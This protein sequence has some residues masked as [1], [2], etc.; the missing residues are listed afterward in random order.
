M[1]PIYR[2][3]LLVCLLTAG[4]LP[5]QY[6]PFADDPNTSVSG[7]YPLYYDGVLN[8]YAVLG[9]TVP[10]SAQGKS[11]GKSK[12][13]GYSQ[14]L[15]LELIDPE[16]NVL[17][18]T[19]LRGKSTALVEAVAYNGQ[20][21]AVEFVDAVDERRYVL[22]FDGEG[23]QIDRHAIPWTVYTAGDAAANLK[24]FNVTS[25]VPV[26]TGFLASSHGGEKMSLRQM[27]YSIKHLSNDPEERAW[28]MRSSSKEKD[29]RMIALGAHAD[30]IGVFMIN[31]KEGILSDKGR[32]QVKGVNLKTGK[33]A[34]S[35]ELDREDIA[36]NISGG[37]YLNGKIYLAGWD[38]GKKGKIFTDPPVGINLMVFDP[39]T[40]LESRERILIEDAISGSLGEMSGNKVKGLGRLFVHEFGVTDAGEVV[41]S[42]EFYREFNGELAARDG[43]TILL[44][45]KLNVKDVQLIN[46]GK[47][48][49]AGLGILRDGISL[50]KSSKI[51]IIGKIKGAFDFMYLNERGQNVYST[52]VS[53][54]SEIRKNKEVTVYFHVIKDGKIIAEE[55]TFAS[56]SVPWILPAQPGYVLIGDE[57][58]LRLERLSTGK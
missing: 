9:R 8:G 27:N 49:N 55:L 44:D 39:A 51:A 53:G 54:R 33:E 5:A 23:T 28:Y 25:L 24:H 16:L 12:G 50:A 36:V 37:R 30:S 38:A 43:I 15:T 1:T 58:G 46:K 40:G 2:L 10:K 52:Y 18:S 41:M 6:Q 19:T 17:G 20:N 29:Y 56:N 32:T 14:Q 7:V 47:S 22:I 57:A 21:I 31:I 35:Y 42:G 34:F 48:G 4:Q 26:S 11:R 45:S 3:L 13:A